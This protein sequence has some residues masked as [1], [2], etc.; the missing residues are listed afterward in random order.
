MNSAFDCGSHQKSDSGIRHR[1]KDPAHIMKT[2]RFL[3]VS[4]VLAAA[5]SA[6]GVTRARADSVEVKGGARILGKITGIHGG[7]VTVQTDYAGEIKVTQSFVTAIT[8]DAPVVVRLANGTSIVG[9]VSSPAPDKVRVTSG[10]KS[11]DSSVGNVASTWIVGDLDPDTRHWSYEAAVD[12]SGKTGTDRALNTSYSFRAKLAGP[13]DTLQLYTNYARQET[14]SELSADQF[15]AGVDYADNFTNR[16]S[17]YVRDETGYDHVNEISLYDIAGAGFG[18]DVIKDDHVQTLT[19]RLGLSYRYD[20]YSAVDTASLSSAGADVGFEYLLK[21]KHWQLSDRISFVPAFQDLGNY[22]LSHDFAFD[23][24]INKS[25]WK[26]STGV[27]NAYNSRPVAGVEKLDTLY[28]TRL[29][30]TWGAGAR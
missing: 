19:L 5:A 24:P 27:T 20:E 13:D 8:T 7:V 1:R 26:F 23:I 25:L 28:F 22:V 18:Y 15:K 10:A 9:V 11:V 4:I 30:L 29:V 14:D 17:W 2:P 16:E 21:T 12:V 3:L 6:L